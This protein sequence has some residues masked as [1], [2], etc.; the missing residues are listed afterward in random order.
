MTI[1]SYSM[2]MKLKSI[3]FKCKELVYQWKC[4]WIIFAN[5]TFIQ[6]YSKNERK[7]SSAYLDEGKSLRNL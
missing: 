2:F 3:E 7:D 4:V 1:G 5:M 6:K